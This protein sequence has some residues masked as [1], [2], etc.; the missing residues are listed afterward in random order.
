MLALEPLLLWDIHE[1]LET[2]NQVIMLTE[3]SSLYRKWFSSWPWIYHEYL[4]LK[5]EI[6]FIFSS[7]FLSYLLH[8][9]FEMKM[10]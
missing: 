1:K 6:E 2:N 9:Y 4:E 5:Y 10:K 8:E 3:A 7:W